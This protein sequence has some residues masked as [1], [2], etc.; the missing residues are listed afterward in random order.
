VI[1]SGYF[2]HGVDTF[3]GDGWMERIDFP[4]DDRIPQGSIPAGLTI[5]YPEAQ[6]QHHLK[7]RHLAID[8]VTAGFG[9][10]EPLQEMD[11]LGALFDRISD[12]IVDTH[13]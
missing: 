6:L 3:R 13:F 12:G 5:L 11:G 2:D 10:L 9:D 1:Q 8:D 4:A 7:M